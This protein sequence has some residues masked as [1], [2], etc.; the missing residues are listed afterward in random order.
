MV[1][2]RFKQETEALRKSWM[3]HPGSSLRDYLVQDVEDPRINTQSI[4]TRHFLIQ[5]LFPARFSAVMEQELRFSL[6]INWLL[7]LLKASVTADQLRT[8]LD[9]LLDGKDNA[10][11]LQIPQFISDTFESLALP[12]YICDLLT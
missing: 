6:V 7:K 5:R 12:N 4:L 8:L 9:A 2:D 10:D 1:Q 3:Q 11:T